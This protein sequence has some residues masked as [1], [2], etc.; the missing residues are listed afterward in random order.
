M[1]DASQRV[2]PRQAL[3]AESQ[4]FE[5]VHLVHITLI[6]ERDDDAW[7]NG[8]TFIEAAEFAAHFVPAVRL[9]RLLAAVGA[10]TQAWDMS[11]DP[12]FTRL[13]MCAAWR[14]YQATVGG[15]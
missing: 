11:L 4:P 9:D 2:W 13:E 12:V 15:E 7:G 1:T 10:V 14:A 3:V 8:G 6:P 5:D